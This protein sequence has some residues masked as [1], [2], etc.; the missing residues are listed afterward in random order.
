MWTQ[1]KERPVGVVTREDIEARVI[2]L[3]ETVPSEKVTWMGKR[4]TK[5]ERHWRQIY[6]KHPRS[7]RM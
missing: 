4:I 6:Q 5:V 7:Q 1:S 2:D 3:D